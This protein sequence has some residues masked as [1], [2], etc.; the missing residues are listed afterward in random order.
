M[1]RKPTPASLRTGQTLYFLKHSLASASGRFSVGFVH[2]MS[3]ALPDPDEGQ[4]GPYPRR[5]L[6]AYLSSSPAVFSYSRR[7]IEGRAK[8]ANH[9]LDV[10]NAK[11]GQVAKQ[12]AANLMEAIKI[13]AAITEAAQ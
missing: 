3:D 4:D 2:V 12:L 6:A 1:K 13:K 8:R 9:E 7:D 5:Y 10:L 11:I